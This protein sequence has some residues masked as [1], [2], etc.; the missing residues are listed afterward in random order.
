MKI[1]A[2]A[3]G[4]AARWG[5]ASVEAAEAPGAFEAK[6]A[7][8]SLGR[9][10][11]L[12]NPSGVSSPRHAPGALDSWRVPARCSGGLAVAHPL[13]CG[14]RR[15]RLSRVSAGRPWGDEVPEK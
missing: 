6:A 3:A 10:E 11:G 5:K 9:Q 12:R 4:A 14:S 1:L 8:A 7:G 13:Q 15:E 2:C